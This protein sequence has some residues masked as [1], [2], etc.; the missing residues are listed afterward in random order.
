MS[1]MNVCCLSLHPWKQTL[2]WRFVCL[3]F[4]GDWSWELHMHGSKRSRIA[5]PGKAEPWCSCSTDLKLMLLGVL[6]FICSKFCHTLKW[7][8]LGFTC[9]PHRFL[10]SCPSLMRGEQSCTCCLWSALEAGFP[11]D[12][13]I[14][15]NQVIPFGQGWFSHKNSAMRCQYPVVPAAKVFSSLHPEG[16]I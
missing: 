5:V 12:A 4:T 6:F 15:L 9:L 3:R 8:G 2:S 7:K 11:W 16:R 14:T 10:Q 1:V 13:D